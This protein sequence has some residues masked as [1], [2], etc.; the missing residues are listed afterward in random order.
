MGSKDKSRKE[1]D[2][3]PV[4]SAKGVSPYGNNLKKEGGDYGVNLGFGRTWD[5]CNRLSA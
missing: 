3:G 4:N 1:E 5:R 2:K